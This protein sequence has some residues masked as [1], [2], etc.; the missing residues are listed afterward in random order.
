MLGLD[1]VTTIVDTT[2][3]PTVS[4]VPPLIAPR[5][6]VMVVV[7]SDTLVAR[8]DVP[9]AATVGVDDDQDTSAVTS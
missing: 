9:I 3:A 6:A 7:P 2:G 8:P 1:G 5:A 4:V